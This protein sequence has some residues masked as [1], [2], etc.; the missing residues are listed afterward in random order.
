MVKCLASL[1]IAQKKNIY[2][3]FPHRLIAGTSKCHLPLAGMAFGLGDEEVFLARVVG[4]DDGKGS[5]DVRALESLLLNVETFEKED[6]DGIVAHGW[7]A[8]H[9]RQPEVEEAVG[10]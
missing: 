10:T 3:M 9:G 2:Q 6:A 5:V 1:L 7:T 8:S 4:E